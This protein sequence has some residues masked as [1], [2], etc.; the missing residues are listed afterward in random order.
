MKTKIQI[1]SILGKVLFEYEKDDNTTK[2]TLEK[3]NLDGANLAGADLARAD[4]AGADLADKGGN[5]IIISKCVQVLGLPYTVILFDTHMKI[6][7]EFHAFKEWW[8]FT[9]KEIAAM[10]GKNA[11]EFWKVWKPILK[12]MS[13]NI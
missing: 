3:A 8:K 1:K 9:D 12:N 6:G 10:D 11:L 5:K 2:D 13:E 4:L 7:C